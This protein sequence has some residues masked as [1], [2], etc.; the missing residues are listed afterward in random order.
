M[1]QA[2]YKSR[3]LLKQ[4]LV[5][6]GA[7]LFQK[8]KKVERPINEF[9]FIYDSDANPVERKNKD[10]KPQWAILVDNY[11]AVLIDTRPPIYI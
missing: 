1:K 6:I 2:D 7:V 4:T 9:T 11:L 5:V 3:A 10:L 8:D